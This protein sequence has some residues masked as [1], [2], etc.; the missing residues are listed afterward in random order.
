MLMEIGVDVKG[1][2]K[3]AREGALKSYEFMGGFFFVLNF[4]MFGV[5]VFL[6]ILN[7]L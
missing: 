2:A 5:D 7:L 3:K 1:L 4:G 6:V